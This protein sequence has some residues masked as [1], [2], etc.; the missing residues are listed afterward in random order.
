MNKKEEE[1]KGKI[2]K[3]IRSLR[4][5][6]SELQNEKIHHIEEISTQQIEIDKMRGI[7]A[8]NE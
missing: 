2:L 1:E 3:E 4:E 7:L 6:Y 5:S 8:M